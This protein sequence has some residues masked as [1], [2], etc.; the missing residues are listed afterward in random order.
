MGGNSFWCNNHIFITMHFHDIFLQFWVLWKS[1]MYIRC[2]TK[3]WDHS[4]VWPKISLVFE[5]F[6]FKILEGYKQNWSFPVSALF[7]FG[8]SRLQPKKDRDWKTSILLVAFWNFK[9]KV[10][11]YL[12]SYRLH[13]TLMPKVSKNPESA[14]C[15]YFIWC[16]NVDRMLIQKM[17]HL[18]VH[19]KK[20]T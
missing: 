4:G 10:L 17:F 14:K 8:A 7:S 6:D 3:F 16:E 12:W 18:I 20:A 11:K 1:N 13:A 19:P 2:L 9:I 15:T 5:D